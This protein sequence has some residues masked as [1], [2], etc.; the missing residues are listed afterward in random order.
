MDWICKAVV[1]AVA[2]AAILAIAR[3]FGR[4]VAG[5]LAGL[6]TVTGPALIWLAV[7]HGE[8]YAVEAA[9]GS[10]AACG[11]CAV[12]ALVYERASRLAGPFVSLLAATVATVASS[13]ALQR[14]APDLVAA[15]ILA[16][17]AS[18]A[19]R[20]AL[21]GADECAGNGTA[22][23]TRTTAAWGHGEPW[24]TAG[25][26]GLVS[27]AVA[28]LAPSVGAYWA[29]VLA[30]P[31]LIAAAVAMREHCRRERHGMRAFLH[32][33]VGGLV[34][35]CGY[36]AVFALL[37]VSTGTLTAAMV[38]TLA[39]CAA[40]F[41]TLRACAAAPARRAVDTHSPLTIRKPR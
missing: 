31:P 19:I 9:I 17:G 28:L 22:N 25:V 26:S 5:L 7:D 11:V 3:R 2:V 33:Y 4:H 12:F 1:T 20:A 18:L 37:L 21:G 23:G 41:A 30:S 10:V 39:G 8:A 36:G 24:L 15:L 34:G 27:G 35:R 16:V 32:G 14:L 6:P 38:A 40:T 13:L 29:G